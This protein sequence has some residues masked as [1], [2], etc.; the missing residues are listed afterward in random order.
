MKRSHVLPLFSYALAVVSC[1]AVLAASDSASRITLRS[2]R[3]PGQTDRVVVKLEVG[4][5]TRYT[6]ND[7]PKTE[8][9]SVVCDLDYFEKTL[10]VPDDAG[11][12][13]RAVRDYKVAAAEVKVGE[14]GFKPALEQQHQLIVAETAK[15]ETLLF[16]PN[17]NLARDELDAIEVPGNSLLLDLLLP[18]KPV[19]VGDHWPHSAELMAAILGLDEVAKT[20]V[21]STLAEATID[22]AR[23]TFKGRVEGAS[24]GVSTAVEVQGKY[25]FN[26]RT[27]RIDWLAMLA[28]EDRNSSFVADGVDAV[29]R[30]QVIVTSAEEPAS[31]SEPALA[32]LT[33]KATP[34]LAHLSYKSPDGSWRCLQDRRW[35]VIHQRAN[36]PVA[37]F[38]LLDRGMLAGQCNVSSLPARAPDKLVS[39]EE[40]QADVRQAL[41]KSFGELVDAGQSANDADY[42]LYRVAVSGTSSEIAMRW[43]YYLVTD[44]LGRQAALTF[45]VEQELAERFGDADKAM[46]QSL[47]FSEPESEDR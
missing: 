23:F 40:F 37:V 4:G 26:R 29:S 32:K 19:K 13:W 2:Q 21:E 9:M 31:L 38:R 18:D 16:S 12:T 44:P 36:S 1:T 10:V 5:K 45:T 17:G 22:V 47:R 28:K 42:R 33:L 41:G 30:L 3:K 11:A 43:V 34:Q 6:D 39:L 14:D 25:R 35:Y 46:V 20:T 7:K 27:G 24:Y 15:Q 8:K